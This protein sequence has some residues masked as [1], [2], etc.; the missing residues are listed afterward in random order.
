MK[1][2]SHLLDYEEE[3]MFDENEDVMQIQ[4]EELK[5]LVDEHLQS[6]DTQT[7]AFWA[8]KLLA[9]DP[10]DSLNQ[11]LPQ[12]AHYLSVCYFYMI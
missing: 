4:S 5:K 6:G 2:S 3:E 11:R 10:G 9:I 1:N 12:I 8:E 7:A